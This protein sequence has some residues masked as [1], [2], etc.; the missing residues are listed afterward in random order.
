MGLVGDLVEV[1]VSKVGIRPQ[2]K[3]KLQADVIART[4]LR[5]D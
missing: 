1:K 5:F 4:V 2:W 3:F